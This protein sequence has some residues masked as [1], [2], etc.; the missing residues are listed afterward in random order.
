MPL[1]VRRL[2]GTVALVGALLCL[3]ALPASAHGPRTIVK[4]TTSTSGTMTTIDAK[5]TYPDKHQAPGARVTAVA[6]SGARQIS[7]PMAAGRS[8]ATFTGHG[9]L[10]PGRW[11]VFVNVLGTSPGAGMS[12]LM[13]SEPSAASVWPRLAGTSAVIVFLGLLGILA[14]RRR[15]LLPEPEPVPADA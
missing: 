3:P 5:V 15:Q 1:S 11:Q 6:V 12:T 7:V 2:V 13:I 8:P 10:E 14:V 9:D 4:V